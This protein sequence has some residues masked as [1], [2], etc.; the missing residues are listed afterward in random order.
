MT[1]FSE[2]TKTLKINNLLKDNATTKEAKDLLSEIAV[3]IN[4]YVLTVLKNEFPDKKIIA[5][6]IQKIFDTLKNNN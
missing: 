6:D 2:L 4:A 1:K 3:L 5:E